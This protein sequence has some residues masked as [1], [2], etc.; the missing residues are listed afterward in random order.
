MASRSPSIEAGDHGHGD[1]TQPRSRPPLG[2]TYVAGA[3][4]HDLEGG[5]VSYSGV[6]GVGHPQ[7]ATA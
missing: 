4:D 7:F 1:K 2:R 5:L 6:A 3:L